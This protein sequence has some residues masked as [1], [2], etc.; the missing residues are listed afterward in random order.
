MRFLS[1]Y[2]T[3]PTSVPAHVQRAPINRRGPEAPSTPSVSY[4]GKDKRAW[5]YRCIVYAQFGVARNGFFGVVAATTNS[6]AVGVVDRWWLAEST[7]SRR[8]YGI[9]SSGSVW[10]V[11]RWWF[12]ESVE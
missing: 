8:E 6:G 1:A 11:D 5:A 4:K 12:I 10:R 2:F 9:T 3:V 7:V